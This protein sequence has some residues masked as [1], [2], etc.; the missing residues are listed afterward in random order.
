MELKLLDPDVELAK[1]DKKMV[2]GNK[3]LERAY[4]ALSA[5]KKVVDIAEVIEAGGY[6][7]EEYIVNQ[8]IGSAQWTTQPTILKATKSVPR[9]ALAR[10]N[11]TH[12][13]IDAT[14]RF[15]SRVG[16][17]QPDYIKLNLKSQIPVEEFT[18]LGRRE[19]FA[20]S[21]VPRVPQTLK[22]KRDDLVLYEAEWKWDSETT[23]VP[24]D[25]ALLRPIGGRLYEVVDVWDTT[26]LEEAVLA[27]KL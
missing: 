20:V 5:R 22:P 6:T 14:N 18:P 26:E 27:E 24:L 7:E 3:A 16:R 2:K 13:R 11:W 1:I 21:V 17:N 19:H 4:K 9:L 8:G 12:T 10:I 15:F 23:Q 25:P